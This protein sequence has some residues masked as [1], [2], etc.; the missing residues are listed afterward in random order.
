VADVIRA[1]ISLVH[2]PRWNQNIYLYL[3]IKELRFLPKSFVN[4][5]FGPFYPP[6]NA[7]NTMTW[8]RTASVANKPGT[9]R[10]TL[11]HLRAATACMRCPPRAGRAHPPWWLLRRLHRLRGFLFR[12]THEAPPGLHLESNTLYRPSPGPSPAAATTRACAWGEAGG[13]QRPRRRPSTVC[14]S[15]EFS[16]TPTP[17][18]PTDLRRGMAS[19]CIRY[20]LRCS[21]IASNSSRL[22]HGLL[23]QTDSPTLCC[24]ALCSWSCSA[25]HRI[26][27]ARQ[28]VRTWAMWC[29]LL[30]CPLN[31]Y[32]LYC[33]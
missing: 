12:S 18:R 26:Q 19:R 30:N 4:A 16:T 1:R 15:P 23:C 11:A 21:S 17:Q 5:F 13:E 32:S 7:H 33:L 2:I 22:C 8:H 25:L 28:N 20:K 10:V 31:R 24:G 3:I 6:T 14:L 9:L 27:P 29:L